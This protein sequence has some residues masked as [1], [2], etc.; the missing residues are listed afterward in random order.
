MA[1]SLLAPA[2]AID[3]ATKPP[4]ATSKLPDAV[5]SKRPRRRRILVEARIALKAK[6]LAL[7]G[8]DFPT[9]DSAALV[10]LFETHGGRMKSIAMNLLGRHADA[11]D[12]VQEAFLRIFRGAARFRGG[13]SLSTWAYRILVNVCYDTLRRGKR[14]PESPLPEESELRGGT[15][16][17]LPLRLAIEKALE[18]LDPRERTAFLLCEVEGFSHREAGEILEVTENTSRTLLFRAKRRLQKELASGGAFAP[19][20]AR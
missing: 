7:T 18:H 15:L 9:A 11:E 6:E 12:A 16:R 19:A 4:A 8:T 14:R 1:R 10:E 2:S 20:E 17:D 5:F 3:S 13:A